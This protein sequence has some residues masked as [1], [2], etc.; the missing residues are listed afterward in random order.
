MM[1][2][3]DQDG[4]GKISANENEWFSKQILDPL[5]GNNYYNYVLL[6][7]G[8]LKAQGLKNFKASFKGNRLVLDFE[9]SFSSPV[10]D[11]YTMLV[12]VVADPTNYIQ[13]TADMENADVD[14]PDAV[15]VEFFNDE[16][17]GLTLFRAFRSGIE[18]LF[19]R[20][21]KK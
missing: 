1:S 20:F 16:L 6:G 18:G 5:K 3:G 4:D 10:T 12:V 11:D 13:I 15:D 19:L 9:T 2:S 14:A 21:K 8:F 7:T 17:K